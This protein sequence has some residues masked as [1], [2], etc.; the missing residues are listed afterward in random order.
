MFCIPLITFMEFKPREAKGEMHAGLSELTSLNLHYPDEHMTRNGTRF[1]AGLAAL[2][3]LVVSGYPTCEEGAFEPLEKLAALRTLD[4]DE[5]GLPSLSF[6][7]PLE[8]IR[9]ESLRASGPGE[10]PEGL[11]GPYQR[12]TRKL[13]EKRRY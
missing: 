5:V 11:F 9:L 13:F 8:N 10:L 2:K 6:L 3:V 12:G 4:V 1:L 7:A